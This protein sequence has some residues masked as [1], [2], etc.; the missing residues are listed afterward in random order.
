MLV[1]GMIFLVK[2]AMSSK[3]KSARTASELMKERLVM[4]PTLLMR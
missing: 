3:H 1:D 4:H 2:R